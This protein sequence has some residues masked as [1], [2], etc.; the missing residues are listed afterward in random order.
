MESYKGGLKTSKWV[1]RNQREH[2]VGPPSGSRV[3]KIPMIGS[4]QFRG[5]AGISNKGGWRNSKR[6]IRS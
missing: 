4:A 6:V 2:V 1:T 5:V 3:H